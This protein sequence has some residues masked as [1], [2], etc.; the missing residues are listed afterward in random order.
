MKKNISTK[1][2]TYYNNYYDLLYRDKDY[3]RESDYVVEHLKSITPNASNIL[4]LGSGTGNYA[5][6]FCESGLRV[7]G[8][9][10]SQQMADIA[11]A[12]NI[13]GFTTVT[14]DIAEFDL[15]EIFD[16]AIALF[17]VVSYL[18]SNKKIIECFNRVNKHL[19]PGSVFIFDVWYSPAVYVQSPKKTV[20]EV[21]Q[22]DLAVS[23]V[24][25]PVVNYSENTVD[26]IY[27]MTIQREGEHKS[28][29]FE[30]THILRHFGTPEIKLFAALTG[31]IFLKAEEFLTSKSPGA[32]T[33]GVCYILQ[34][35]A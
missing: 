21:K 10:I 15:N 33:W 23:R 6:H 13:Q 14:G 22:G 27:E 2:F 12:K 8:I 16:G 17:H 29:K 26:V 1:P 7:T 19:K 11:L 31:F 25:H 34:K 28:E 35:H 5:K 30:E 9:E 18:V 4:E 24:A 20:K 3:K 32:D